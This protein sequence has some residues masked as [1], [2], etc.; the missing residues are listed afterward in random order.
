MKANNNSKEKNIKNIPH[1]ENEI[2][3]EENPIQDNNDINNNGQEI[4]LKDQLIQNF[5]FYANINGED[6]DPREVSVLSGDEKNR[7]ITQIIKFL[8]DSYPIEAITYVLQ[9]CYYNTFSHTSVLDKIIKY[10]LE[11]YKELGED[12]ITNLIY[13]YKENQ[14]NINISTV[15]DFNNK[16]QMNFGNNILHMTKLVFYDYSKE[17]VE[18]RKFNMNEIFIEIKA[19]CINNNNLVEEDKNDNIKEGLSLEEN[20]AQAMFLGEKHHLFKRF[21]RRKDNIYVFNFIGFENKKVVRKPNKK[22]KKRRKKMIMIK[23]KKHLNLLLFSN[24]KKKDAMLYTLIILIRIDSIKENRIVILIMKL[25]KK[26][27]LI[28]MSKILNCLRKKIILLIF[29]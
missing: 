21:C 28:I 6:F 18:F 13:S 20:N 26:K 3:Q 5:G 12:T 19:N 25:K 14:L 7:E 17:G 4:P 16:N 10:L 15:N 23:I 24:V 1:K 27:C 11:K 9:R 8:F 29:S 22:R 2:N